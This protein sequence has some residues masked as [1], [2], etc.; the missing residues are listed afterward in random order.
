MRRPETAGTIVEMTTIPDSVRDFL[1]AGL[2]AHVV[3]RKRNGDP[4]VNL[5]WAGLDGDELVFASFFDAKRA[6]RVRRDPRVTL[7]FHAPA[8]DGPA[9]H[10]YLA[11]DG[12]ARVAD[13]GALDVMDHLAVVH[14][15]GNCVSEPRH[16][17][18]LD[19]PRLDRQDLRAGPLERPLAGDGARK[20]R[21]PGSIG[22]IA[23]HGDAAGP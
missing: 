21:P 16:A 14:R 10:P 13:G 7:S 15:A 22:D 9:L 3:T 1:S 6:A 2:W 18:R 4:H 5:T 20:D 8:Y 19:V 11:I 17:A 23:G 12:H